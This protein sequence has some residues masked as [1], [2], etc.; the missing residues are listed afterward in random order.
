MG[1]A[2]REWNNMERSITLGVEKVAMSSAALANP[3]LIA[4]ASTVK[5]S[6]RIVVG[7]DLM[8]VKSGEEYEVFTHNGTKATGVSPAAFAKAA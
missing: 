4:R 8:H 5:G 7:M 6:K 1:E 3:D 2:Y